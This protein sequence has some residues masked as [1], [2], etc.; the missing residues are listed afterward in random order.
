MGTMLRKYLE[1]E[2]LI[3]EEDWE[4]FDIESAADG[5]EK[6]L[7]E[8]G[9]VDVDVRFL[10]KEGIAEDVKE[11]IKAHLEE[12]REAMTYGLRDAIG[13]VWYGKRRK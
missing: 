8:E 1:V 13:E 6:A 5:I 2:F 7:V 10:Q 12:E 11:E 9:A 3:D 4:H